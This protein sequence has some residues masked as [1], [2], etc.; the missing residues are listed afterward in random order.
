MYLRSTWDGKPD[1]AGKEL[2]MAG[3]IPAAFPTAEARQRTSV[4]LLRSAGAPLPAAEEAR[5]RLPDQGLPSSGAAAFSCFVHVWALFVVVVSPSL[6]SA[7]TE[8][9]HKSLAQEH[10]WELVFSTETLKSIILSVCKNK[11]CCNRARYFGLSA[12]L[13]RGVCP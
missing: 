10:P 5:A 8:K 2:T 3:S 13:L 4:Q 1:E 7:G 6:N 9:C 11:T 12:A